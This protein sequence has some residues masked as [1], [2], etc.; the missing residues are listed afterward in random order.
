MTVVKRTNRIVAATPIQVGERRLLP[1]VMVM[2]LVCEHP[3][4]PEFQ[5]VRI[6]PV[7]LVEEGPEGTRWHAIPDTTGETL[8]VLVAV[9]LTVAFIAGLV[10]FLSSLAE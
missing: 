5:N 1:S 2:T 10:I 3:K 8:S 4:L 6:R 7:S 9:G